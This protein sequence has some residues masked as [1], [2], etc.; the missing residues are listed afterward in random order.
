MLETGIDTG[1]EAVTETG[2]VADV[3]TAAGRWNLKLLE[4]SS[5]RN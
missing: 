3:Q 2:F 1:S 5:D 4:G